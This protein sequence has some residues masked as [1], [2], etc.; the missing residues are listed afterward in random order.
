MAALTETATFPRF[1]LV[2]SES[3]FKFCQFCQFCQS[4]VKELAARPKGA[5][6]AGS[7]QGR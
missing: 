6:M 7:S 5:M 2:E 3:R 1:D 4:L